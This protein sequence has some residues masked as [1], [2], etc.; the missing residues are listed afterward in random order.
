MK[1]H[2]LSDLHTEHSNFS[3]PKTEADIIVLAGDIG[4][5]LGGLDWLH[6]QDIEQPVLYIP[7]NHDFYHHDTSLI[8]SMK[9]HAQDN[10]FILNNEMFDIG[11]VRFLGTTLWADF[12][13]FGASTQN[14][15]MDYAQKNLADF[16]VITHQGKPFNPIDAIALHRESL[17]WLKEKLNDGYSGTTIVITHH[18]PSALSVHPKYKDDLITAAFVSPL[19]DLMGND[20]VS[21]WIHGHMHKAFDY[22]ISGTRVICNPR[23]HPPYKIHNG[24]VSDLVV[25]V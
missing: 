23:G 7:G 25:N 20:K 14:E 24:F 8:Q 6:Q 12:T 15:A 3:L 18:A 16:S 1:I 13:H 4:V 5:G 10:V 21:L 11:D 17:Q 2:I 9:K 22:K 19:D